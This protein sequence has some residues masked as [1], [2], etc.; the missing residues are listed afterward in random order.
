[1]GACS[2]D[3][4]MRACDDDLA[5][6]VVVGDPDVGVGAAACDVN[7]L[8]VEAEDRGHRAGPFEPGIVHCG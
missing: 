7:V 1:M 6:G 2:F 4:G 3:A 5:R 8:V